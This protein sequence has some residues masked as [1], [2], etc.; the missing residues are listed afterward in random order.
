VGVGDGAGRR[1]RLGRGERGADVVDAVVGQRLGAE[2]H[3]GRA[4]VDQAV[5][6]HGEEARAGAATPVDAAALQELFLE[7]L[8]EDRGAAAIEGGDLREHRAGLGVEGQGRARGIAGQRALGIEAQG[9]DRARDRQGL[10]R[11]R[12]A[13]DGVDPDPEAGV[14]GEEAQLAAQRLVRLLADR[15]G[16]QVVEGEL[17]RVEPGSVE[18]PDPLAAV[19]R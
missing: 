9:A 1:A 16:C 6:A 7:V 13:E 4:Q 5:L 17:E 18:G 3:L 2:P 12:R 19:S 10:G 15:V 8:G 14:L 11:G